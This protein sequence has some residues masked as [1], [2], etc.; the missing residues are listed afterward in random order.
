VQ[1]QERSFSNG[2][3][4]APLAASVIVGVYAIGGLTLA[5]AALSPPTYQARRTL[6]A[7]R[8]QDLAY[9]MEAETIQAPKFEVNPSTLLPLTA[10]THHLN[11]GAVPAVSCAIRC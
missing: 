8:T 2:W 9:M 10:R 6:A 7:E 3:H 4:R 5:L 1:P 11:A